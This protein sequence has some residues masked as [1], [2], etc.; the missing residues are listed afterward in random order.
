M[1]GYVNQNAVGR[2]RE[3]LESEERRRKMVEHNYAVASKFYSYAVL[4]HRLHS[5]ISQ[6]SG[7]ED[8]PGFS[9]PRGFRLILRHL[10]HRGPFHSLDLEN[11]GV[12]FV[13]DQLVLDHFVEKR[14]LD[15]DAVPAFLSGRKKVLMMV[16]AHDP[17]GLGILVF[18]DAPVQI[19]LGHDVEPPPLVNVQQHAGLD[20]VADGKGYFFEISR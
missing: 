20:P 4:R 5:L 10:D 11:I 6:F 19:D 8:S 18:V 12:R 15:I 9:R 17:Q 13:I 2:I 7:E 3:V 14:F 1:D 16:K